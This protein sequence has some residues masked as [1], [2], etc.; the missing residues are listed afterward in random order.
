MFHK[1]P[2]GLLD[3]VA[4]VVAVTAVYT[5]TPLGGLADRL[6]DRALNL[7]PP[8]RPL[9][10]YFHLPDPRLAEVQPGAKLVSLPLSATRPQDRSLARIQTGLDPDLVRAF[11]QVAAGGVVTADRSGTL[12]YDLRPLPHH[13]ADRAALG[14][15][16]VG[17]TVGPDL[18]KGVQARLADAL[19]IL[20]AARRQLGGDDAAL[21]A[22]ALG[23]QVVARAVARARARHAPRPARLPGFRPFLLH[24]DAV[25]AAHFVSAVEDLR[26]AYT[27]RW[28]VPASVP[29][30][31]PYGMRDHP[32]LHTDLM[33]DGVDLGARVG[34]PIDAT[35]S[36]KVIYAGFDGLNGNYV[37]ID[38]GYGLDTAYCHAE[39]LLVHT[40]ERVSRGQPIALVGATGRA[41]GPHLHY[42][43]F[44]G[45]RPVDPLVFRPADLTL[46]YAPKDTTAEP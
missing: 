33:H 28:P 1:R 36:G 12:W 35:A 6:V 5:G 8:T 27:M 44:V 37:K 39:K 23:D 32:I 22:Y 25:R 19:E 2:S 34:T 7:A 20:R 46:R 14:L 15:T 24:L 4:T 13:D 38:H 30:T 43:I 40:G 26:T 21:A 41:T 16:P 42:A 18:A 29:V 11:A 3:L 17:E 31:S 10:A 9:L 45:G